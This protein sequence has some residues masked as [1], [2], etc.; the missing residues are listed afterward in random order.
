MKKVLV[1]LLLIFFIPVLL[2]FHC[3]PEPAVVNPQETLFK[4]L[5]NHRVVMLADFAHSSAYPYHTLTGFLQYWLEKAEQIGGSIRN[6][7]LVLEMD[8]E[9]QAAKEKFIHTG[10]LEPYLILFPDSS[11][12][13]IEYLFELR[14][15]FKKITVKN[16]KLPASKKLSFE[17]LGAED[18]AGNRKAFFT[19]S[20]DDGYRWFVKKRDKL[21]AKRVIEYAKKHQDRKLLIFYGGAHLSSTFCRKDQTLAFPHIDSWGYYLAY[22]LKNKLG[23]A[24]VKTINQECQGFI[25]NPGLDIYVRRDRKKI[26]PGRALLFSI[27]PFAATFFRRLIGAPTVDATFVLPEKVISPHF[28]QQLYCT[29]NFKRLIQKALVLQPHI[30][31][32]WLAN[33]RFQKIMSGLKFISG[34]SFNS[35]EEYQTWLETTNF[36]ASA[37]LNIERVRQL[38]HNS[39]TDRSLRYLLC[40][41]M[42]ERPWILKKGNEEKILHKLQILSSLARALVGSGKEQKS[43][44][45]FLCKEFGFSPENPVQF[46]KHW[47]QKKYGLTH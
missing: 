46:I 27:P 9:S 33:R 34:Q 44:G 7:T 36:D 37:Y 2:Y 39:K 22:Y 28:L 25:G 15:I 6:L 32:G 26:P 38:I 31:K 47:R 19:M 30:L 43:A 42:G 40:K 21:S 12:E 4:E 8:E 3:F 45:L 13:T 20:R 10:N 35:P 29:K 41:T 23:S 5:A 1:A 18:I 14:D 16:K 17:I 24:K 11:L